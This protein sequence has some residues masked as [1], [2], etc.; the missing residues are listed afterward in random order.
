MTLAE[1][2]AEWV[3]E[4]AHSMKLEGLE[5]SDDFHA[6]SKEYVAGKITSDD[7]VKK[8]RARFGLD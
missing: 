7:L 1:Q 3:N 8:A 2:R 5:V 6:E 4:A